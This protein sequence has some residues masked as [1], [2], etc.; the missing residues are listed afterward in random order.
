MERLERPKP[1]KRKPREGAKDGPSSRPDRRQFRRVRQI[2]S[3]EGNQPREAGQFFT[4]DTVRLA[5]AGLEGRR[6]AAPNRRPRGPR[7]PSIL[8][9]PVFSPEQEHG[10]GDQA[11]EYRHD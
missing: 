3:A 6:A 10:H 11:A 8:I 5:V 7:N 9:V 4:P 2:N 1:E